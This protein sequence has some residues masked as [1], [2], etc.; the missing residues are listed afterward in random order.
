MRSAYASLSASRNIR[1]IA[2]GLL[3]FGSGC[4]AIQ[5]SSASS[6]SG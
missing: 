3:G 2:S 4:W 5:A 1:L 6:M